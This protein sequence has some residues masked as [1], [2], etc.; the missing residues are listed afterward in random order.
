MRTHSFTDNRFAAALF[1]LILLASL[2][3]C[4]SS[5]TPLSSTDSAGTG[6]ETTS[7]TAVSN[8]TTVPAPPATAGDYHPNID[9]SQFTNR[10]TNEY[11]P[12]APGSVRILDGTKDGLPQRHVAT[13]TNK[14]KT[15]MGVDCVVVE[16]VVTTNGALV[17]KTSDWYAQNKDGSVW[18]FGEATADYENGVV[19]STAGSWEAGVDHALPGMIMETTPKPGPPYYTEYRPGIAEDQ[20]EVLKTGT[21][22]T[23]KGGHRYTNV[24]VIRDTNPLDPSMVQHKWYAPG[25][26]VVQSVRTGSSHVEHS[27]LVK[28]TQG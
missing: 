16:D 3:G 1:A 25:F 5:G 28:L 11:F 6:A 27:H 7:T 20:A 9:P 17:E 4:G 13:V 26:G 21:S 15:I 18:Y 22:V 24:V 14:T 19:T 8:T 2:A 10:I 23:V 12:L